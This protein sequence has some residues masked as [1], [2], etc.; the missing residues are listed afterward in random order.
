MSIRPIKPKDHATIAQW[1]RERGQ[2]MPHPSSLSATG[3]ICDERVAL[4]LYLTNSNLAFIEGV[5]SSPN[6]TKSLRKQSFN[7]LIGFSVDFCLAAGYT[8]ILGITKH[9]S[10][11]EIGKRY[12]FKILKEHQVLYLNAD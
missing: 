9:P 1:Y 11:K 6:T 2:V 12:G 5:I 8:Q 10:V 3:F 7:K 4:W